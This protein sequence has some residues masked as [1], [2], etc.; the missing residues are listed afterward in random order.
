VASV[1]RRGL[2]PAHPA[3]WRTFPGARRLLPR[4][5][6]WGPGRT[7]LPRAPHFPPP[8]EP[9]PLPPWSPLE[10]RRVR[11]HVRDGIAV[12]AFSAAASSAVAVAMILLTT[13][14]G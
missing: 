4:A 6:G 2:R 5:S 12:A 9:P 1:V 7:N 11:E 8:A 13:L 10:K 14:A 3:F